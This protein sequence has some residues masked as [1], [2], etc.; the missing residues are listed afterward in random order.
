MAVKTIPKEKTPVFSEPVAIARPQKS[1]EREGFY[2]PQE[3]AMTKKEVEAKLLSEMKR[4]LPAEIYAK[5]GKAVAEVMADRIVQLNEEEAVK[6]RWSKDTKTTRYNV[7]EKTE[8]VLSTLSEIAKCKPNIIIDF[9]DAIAFADGETEA[10][11]FVKCPRE[12]VDL[13]KA[14]D[15]KFMGLVFF[16]IKEIFTAESLRSLAIIAKTARPRIKDYGSATMQ[17]VISS[18]ASRRNSITTLDVYEFK[19]HHKICVVAA[20]EAKESEYIVPALTNLMRLIENDRFIIMPDKPESKDGFDEKDIIKWSE[21]CG[22]YIG[23]FYI[24]LANDEFLKF[25]SDAKKAVLRELHNIITEYGLSDKKICKILH[26]LC[27]KNRL[28]TM[29]KVDS[30][31]K[32]IS[33]FDAKKIRASQNEEETIRSD[34]RSFCTETIN[35]QTYLDCIQKY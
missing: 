12:T 2:A 28:V 29:E 18:I 19:R 7:P 33:G 26:A 3:Q 34:F 10:G 23:L 35:K 8:E 5:Y 16:E 20:I 17:N 31:L 30:D 4:T 14:A 11:M 32:T 13:H 6:T 15:G 27:A 22:K 9:M 1:K 25:D 21:F 24:A